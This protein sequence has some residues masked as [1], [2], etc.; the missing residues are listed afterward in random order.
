MVICGAG[1]RANF[2]INNCDECPSTSGALRNPA[3]GPDECTLLGDHARPRFELA[4]LCQLVLRAG[5]GRS[6]FHDR[7]DH[8]S[9]HSM[10]RRRQ[11]RHKPSSCYAIQVAS[12][13]L[14]DVA[15]TQWLLASSTMEGTGGGDLFASARAKKSGGLRSF[16]SRRAEIDVASGGIGPPHTEVI[17]YL[18]FVSVGNH[19]VLNLI[20]WNAP[21]AASVARPPARPSGARP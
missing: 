1:E 11:L 10:T 12:G 7:P 18:R 8:R 4:M 6:S 2:R 5:K 21:A 16:D 20:S 19:F 17:P 3:H 14:R 15:A 13:M 9:L